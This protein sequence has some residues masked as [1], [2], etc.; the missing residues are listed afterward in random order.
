VVAGSA[1][2]RVTCNRDDFGRGSWRRLEWIHFKARM[3]DRCVLKQM[4]APIDCSAQFK[5]NRQQTWW[6]TRVW[7]LV[8][9]IAILALFLGPRGNEATFSEGQ[10]TFQL[11]CV[12][13]MMIS[14]L[15]TILATRKY[16][17]CP[18]CDEVPGRSG[19]SLFPYVCP[20]CGATLM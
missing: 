20:N 18:R 17:I 5:R 9:A 14:G 3:V 7:C 15:A 10:F 13:V 11:V 19:V 2:K 4:T 12:V 1:S 16:Y 6:A 8:E